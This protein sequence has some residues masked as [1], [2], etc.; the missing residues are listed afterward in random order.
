M[1]FNNNKLSDL[2]DLSEYSLVSL[3]VSNNFIKHKG[4]QFSLP[5]NIVELDLSNNG[6]SLAGFIDISDGR[7]LKYINI[8]GSAIKP[9]DHEIFERICGRHAT[10]I[11]GGGDDGPNWL[12]IAIIAIIVYVLFMK[13]KK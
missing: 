13:K 11:G 9:I 6:S 2:P 1:Y 3:D 12:M 10:C 5:Y 7:R 4:G 8:S